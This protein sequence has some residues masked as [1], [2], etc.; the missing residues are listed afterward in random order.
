MN[1]T[2]DGGGPDLP[3]KTFFSGPSL[4]C[5]Q[6]EMEAIKKYFSP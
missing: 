4:D 2:R 1:F 5:E 3:T 6:G